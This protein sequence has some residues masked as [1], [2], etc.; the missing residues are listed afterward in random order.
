MA[1]FFA[2]T[3]MNQAHSTDSYFRFNALSSPFAMFKTVTVGG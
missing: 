1:P 3:R 2:L